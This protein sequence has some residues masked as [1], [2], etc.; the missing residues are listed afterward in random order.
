MKDEGLLPSGSF[1]ARGAA[2]G[3]SRAAELGVERFAMPT[4]GN[5]GAAWALYGARAGLTATVVMPVDAPEITRRECAA[6]GADLHLVDGLISD[7]GRIVSELV[8]A[9]GDRVFDA[10]TLKEPYRI[11]GKK[12]MGLEIVEQLGWTPPDVILY[13]TGGGVGLIGIRKALTELREL[14]WISGPFPRLVAVQAEGCAPVVEAFERGE[15]VTRPWEKA[16]TV[17]FGINVPKPLGDFLILDAL[18]ETS[19]TAVAVT[20]AE[21]LAELAEVTALEGAFVCPEG[22]AAFA[23]AR[24][25]RASGWLGEDERVVVLNTGAGLKYPEARVDDRV[26]RRPTALLH[27]PH[28]QGGVVARPEPVVLVH[29]GHRGQRAGR[30]GDGPHRCRIAD[31]GRGGADPLDVHRHLTGR[32]R[33]GQ[34]VAG[35]PLQFVADVAVRGAQLKR[36]LGT[37]GHD[38]GRGARTQDPDVHPGVGGREAGQ[39]VQRHRRLRRGE[40]GVA[41]LLRGGGR[42]RLAPGEDRPQLRV[43]EEAVRAGG[44]LADRQA[45]PQMQRV[46]P[47]DAREDSRVQHRAG[48]SPALLGGWNSSRTRPAIRPDESRRASSRPTAIWPSWPQA[49]IAPGASEANPSRAGACSGADDSVSGSASMSTRSAT[50]GP[51]ASPS[52]SATT[53]VCPSRTGARSSSPAPQARARAAAASSS[54]RPGRPGR[55]R[56]RSRRARSA[57]AARAAAAPPRWR[58]TSTAR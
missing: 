57:R 53:A 50:V 37:P 1:K 2:V 34:H 26:R 14:G 41:S 16:S 24:K 54:S 12:T 8:A 17:A 42:M 48:A 33:S 3:V 29:G 47:V 27:V 13:P 35:A 5:A 28:Q 56:G 9:S 30:A 4:N 46:Q 38:V 39:R 36:H 43:G 32:S 44:D 19:G 52:M 23:A 11:E 10:S 49:C 58:P 20:D 31:G 51:G 21:L 18:A 45:Q 40:Q 6:S 25:L 15:R 55:G 7:A 22:A